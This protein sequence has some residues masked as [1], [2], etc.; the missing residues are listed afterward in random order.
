VLGRTIH[1]MPQIG[2][3]S[4]GI[5]LASG[6]GGHGFN[7]TAMAGNLVARAVVHGDDAWRLFLPFEL[8][9]TGGLAGRVAAQV[10]CWWKRSRDEAKA[11]KARNRAAGA[12]QA[13]PVRRR[14]RPAQGH[15]DR[16]APELPPAAAMK[17]PAVALPADPELP[18]AMAVPPVSA[19]DQ[20]AEGQRPSRLAM[21]ASRSNR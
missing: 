9:W 2:E 13:G 5:W 6:F 3:L 14:A 18:P 19:D 8:I 7:T 12:R 16:A 17:L 1:N 10:G 21:N 11:Q 4:P 15:M 20:P